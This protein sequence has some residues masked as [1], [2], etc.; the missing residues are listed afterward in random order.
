MVRRN[1]GAEERTTLLY[2]MEASEEEVLRVEMAAA[3]GEKGASKKRGKHAIAL[4]YIPDQR[5]RQAHFNK[6]VKSLLRHGKELEVHTGCETFILVRSSEEPSQTHV[7]CSHNRS[8][9]SAIDLLMKVDVNML[10]QCALNDLATIK[11]EFNSKLCKTI[12]KSQEKFTKCIQYEVESC[13]KE[14]QDRA[15][16]LESIPPFQKPRS[17]RRKSDAIFPFQVSSNIEHNNFP[18]A[19][20]VSMPQTNFNGQMQAPTHGNFV[21]PTQNYQPLPLQGPSTSYRGEGQ[22]EGCPHSNHAW[23]HYSNSHV[24]QA[25]AAIARSNMCTCLNGQRAQNQVAYMQTRVLPQHVNIQVPPSASMQTIDYHEGGQNQSYM[26][27][28]MYFNSHIHPQNHASISNIVRSSFS[29]QMPQTNACVEDGV[30]P[31]YNDFHASTLVVPSQHN[32]YLGE[33]QVLDVGINSNGG[34]EIIMEHDNR[35]VHQPTHLQQNYDQGER[36]HHAQ[37]DAKVETESNGFPYFAHNVSNSMSENTDVP[38]EMN[39]PNKQERCMMDEE[40]TPNENDIRNNSEE[41]FKQNK[42]GAEDADK[43]NEADEM[44]TNF[45]DIGH[46]FNLP[47]LQMFPEINNSADVHPHDSYSFD[48]NRSM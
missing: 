28:R 44:D 31:T 9:R 27:P 33:G 2:K 47:D 48:D 29:Q 37:T 14:M 7:F 8:V 39:D 1:K 16:A 13:E 5:R 6:H 45:L 32:N 22:L 24:S 41:V 23:M 34:L 4:G 36:G 40:C 46:L 11:T 35:N 26:N 30:L 3:F 21:P 43:S 20:R 38:I 18:M 19:N 10:E 15:Q 12:T 42:F 25:T 17:K